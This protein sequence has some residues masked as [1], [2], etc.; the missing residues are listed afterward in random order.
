MAGLIKR[1][2]SMVRPYPGRVISFLLLVTVSLA[3]VST[4]STVDNSIDVWQTRD[5]AAWRHY[6]NFVSRNGVTDPLVVYLPITQSKNISGI[7]RG[8]EEKHGIIE[9][10]DYHDVSF[11]EQNGTLVTVTPKQGLRGHE[12]GALVDDVQA[13][14]S[15][16]AAQ[17]HM[18]GVWYLTHIL[19]SMSADTTRRL[20]PLVIFLAAFAAWLMTRS[21]SRTV[22][23]LSCGL[24]PAIQLAGVMSLL[25]EPFNMV[26]LALPPMVMILGM[27]HAV[28][29]LLRE[30]T[31]A[32]ADPIIIYSAVAPPCLLAAFTTMLGFLSLTLGDYEP[33]RKLGQWG[34]FGAILSAVT[35]L[36]L[37]PPFLRSSAAESI[38]SANLAVRFTEFLGRNRTR[39]FCG[40]LLAVLLAGYGVSGLERGSHIL[41]FFKKDAQVRVDYGAIEGSGVGLTP[42]E[43]DFHEKP[44]S[45]RDI[46][47]VMDILAKGHEDITHFILHFQ[48]NGGFSLPVA[49][50]RGAEFNLP[51]MPLALFGSVQRMTI[52]T[53]TLESEKTLALAEDVESVFTSRLGESEQPYVTGTVPLYAS[54]Q[55]LLFSSMVKS[56]LGAFF[57]I[58]LIVALVLRSFRLGLI[59]LL[60]NVLPVY[61]IVGAMGLLDIP[62]SVATVTVASIVFGIVIDDTIHFLHAWQAR[63]SALSGME[64][65][66]AVVSHV[67]S[68]MITTTVVAGFGFLGF[69]FS[70]LLPLR[71]FGLLITLALV[72][73]LICDLLILP[74]LLL[75][76]G[77]GK[78]T[79]HAS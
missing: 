67:G 48:E 9:K 20:F 57:S 36:L 72:L 69:L 65:L 2:G 68:A 47:S 78:K 29:F 50:S 49:T 27:A 37:M 74:L 43:I 39:I 17:K 55:R 75:L 42:L 44:G 12:M 60:P 41:A 15:Q 25:C 21:V 61:F 40:V 58:S 30:K 64:R 70:P 56:F 62:L 18:G 46:R 7:A 32:G 38:S 22:L 31:S 8:L 79:I 6:Q 1:F 66:A 52:L 23:V 71:N 51:I 26:L 13:A 3:L 16:V 5:S 54:G 34:A 19:D 76:V 10:V 28:H 14:F 59:A 33:V 4:R 11:G 73:A 63:E 53:R 77:K 45:L 24:A 35:P